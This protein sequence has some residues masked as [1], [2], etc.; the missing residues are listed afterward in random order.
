M[1][2]SVNMKSFSQHTG[3]LRGFILRSQ[4]IVILKKS[5]YEET[6]EH[7]ID[8][9]S[10]DD[11]RDEYP[12][13]PSIDVSI[14]FPMQVQCELLNHKM[15]LYQQKIKIRNATCDYTINSEMFMNPSPYVSTAG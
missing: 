10:I 15:C 14:P 1:K 13:Y 2:I 9:V 4:L 3:R 5:F 11:F 12:R 6:Q 8:D 7:W